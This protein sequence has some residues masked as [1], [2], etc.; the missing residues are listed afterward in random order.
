M[1]VATISNSRTIPLSSVVRG[2]IGSSQIS[3]PVPRSQVL[4]ARFKHISGRPDPSGGGH[5]LGKLRSLDNL[6]DRLIKL[7]ESKSGELPGRDSLKGMSEENLDA[8]IQDLSR[9]LHQAFVKAE[10]NPYLNP[11]S[12]V[13]LVADIKL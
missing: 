10:A 7:K 1:Q 5:S 3:L 4:Y 8:L 13:G 11:G 12:P 2:S 9:K 6:I